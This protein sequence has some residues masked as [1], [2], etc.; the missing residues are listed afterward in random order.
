MTQ[1]GRRWGERLV[2]SM[3]RPANSRSKSPHWSLERVHR[4]RWR[5]LRSNGRRVGQIKKWRR[6][7]TAAWAGSA[8]PTAG[9]SES[10]G[11]SCCFVHKDPSGFCE[12]RQSGVREGARRKSSTQQRS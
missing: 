6:T 9:A 12:E 3:T 10:E 7:P 5:H 1:R 2:V 11:S 4:T 8:S